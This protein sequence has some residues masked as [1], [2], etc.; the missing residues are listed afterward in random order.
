[1]VVLT[2]ALLAA[3]MS[4]V[5][6]LYP[7]SRYISVSG[8]RT[9]GAEG[10]IVSELTKDNTGAKTELEADA[11]GLDRKWAATSRGIV[12][13]R[14]DATTTGRLLVSCTNRFT[15]SPTGLFVCLDSQNG[16]IRAANQASGLLQTE[17]VPFGSDLYPIPGT[18]GT[19]LITSPRYAR[20]DHLR[21]IIAFDSTIGVFFKKNRDD[22]PV[23]SIQSSTMIMDIV[24]DVVFSYETN[25]GILKRYSGVTGDLLAM[26]TIPTGCGDI[27]GKSD[28]EIICRMSSGNTV[29]L[30]GLQAIHASRY[31]YV[32]SVETIAVS[33][34]RG[35]V[36]EDTINQ[37]DVV[38]NNSIN[39]F[40]DNPSALFNGAVSNSTSLYIKNAGFFSVPCGSMEEFPER[41]ILF[42]IDYNGGTASS[43]N[44]ST[45]SVLWTTALPVAPEQSTRFAVSPNAE[46]YIPVGDVVVLVNETSSEIVYKADQNIDSIAVSSKYIFLVGKDLGL[47]VLNARNVSETIVANGNR[48]ATV[49]ITGDTRFFFTISNDRIDAYSQDTAM[50]LSVFALPIL[51]AEYTSASFDS[52]TNKIHYQSSPYGVQSIQVVQNTIGSSSTG[53]EDYEIVLIVVLS[54]AAVAG[55]LFIAVNSKKA[56]AD[57]QA[58]DEE[59]SVVQSELLEFLTGRIRGGYTAISI[60]GSGSFG[61]VYKAHLHSGGYMALKIIDCHNIEDL[62]LSSSEVNAMEK[63]SHNNVIKFYG[64]EKLENEDKIAIGLELL[65]GGSLKSIVRS[66]G[67]QES[68]VRYYMKDLTEAVRFIHSHGIVHRDIKADNVLVDKN[69]RVVLS[70]FGCCKDVGI[71]SDSS[72]I[73]TPT[74]TIKG[75]SGSV[76]FMAPEVIETVSSPTPPS[77]DPSKKRYNLSSDIWS[78]GCTTVELLNGNPPWPAELDLLSLIRHMAE[79]QP[80]V[81]DDFS[82]LAKDFLNSIFVPAAVRPTAEELLEHPFLKDAE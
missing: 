20:S 19:F 35:D 2:I 67:I 29:F 51:Q 55:C 57:E 24:G 31:F 59:A 25:S 3:T 27:I 48:T 30:V 47:L 16:V 39:P 17:S 76:P 22:A 33:L 46:L 74:S 50:H 26:E 65:E 53:L 79:N 12:E 68:T 5:Q 42:C 36:C 66:K 21:Y 32:S 41:N 10:S 69:G 73:A 18:N 49:V 4:Q 81:P 1:M 43:V 37:P 61:V 64:M 45:G 13:I 78:L 72:S 34:C 8:S 44:K 70:D 7:S 14:G 82:S 62:A 54:T 60:L 9:L 40:I 71:A 80:S 23:V 6:Q 77:S 52:G 15:A 58:G 56:V 11:V 38:I 63:L 75:L 28:R